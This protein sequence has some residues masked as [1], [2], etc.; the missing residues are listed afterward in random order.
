[1]FLQLYWRYRN[2]IAQGWLRP[3]DRVPSVRSLASEVGV[4]RGTVEKAYELLVS[5]GYLLTR[6]QPEPWCRPWHAAW[7]LAGVSVTL[8]RARR[9]RWTRRLQACSAG[10]SNSA[11]RRSMHSPARCGNAWQGVTCA[12]WIRQPWATPKRQVMSRYAVPLSTTWSAHEA[13]PAHTSR[14][15]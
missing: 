7:V 6:G 14:C 13:L 1:M 9:L 8:R 3:G 10:P 2:A 4:A 5:E 15:S 12:R 11:C